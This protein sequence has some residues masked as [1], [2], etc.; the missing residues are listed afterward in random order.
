MQFDHRGVIKRIFKDHFDGF[1]KLHQGRF[2]AAYRQDIEETVQKAMRCGS[3][4]LGYIRYECLGC[5]GETRPV[6][7]YFS[8]KSRFCNKCG[9]K[10]TDDWSDKQQ[11]LIFNVPHRHMVFTIPEEIRQVF[12]QD[13]KKLNEL[14]ILVADVFEYYFQQRNKKPL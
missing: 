9:K 13:R 5:P 6:F 2:P 14:S 11:E 4:D 3:R 10:Y 1:W 12:F 7:I 8:C